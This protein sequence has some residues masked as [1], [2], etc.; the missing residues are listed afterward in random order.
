[1]PGIRRLFSGNSSRDFSPLTE[2]WQEFMLDTLQHKAV[3]KVTPAGGT[4]QITEKG[5]E[6]A[7]ATAGVQF[8]MGHFPVHAT[9]TFDRPFFLFI[10]DAL[11]K[12]SLVV[13]V[14]LVQVV[15]FWGRVVQ[16]QPIFLPLATPQEEFFGK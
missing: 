11:N 13:R 6:A 2:R 9:V 12:V 5:T 7:A 3:I 1:M 14:T 16:P 15:I 4:P 10:Y 8:Y